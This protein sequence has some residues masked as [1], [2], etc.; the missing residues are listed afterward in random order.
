MTGLEVFMGRSA[1]DTLYSLSLLLC[2][3][4]RNRCSSSQLVTLL[5]A[6]VIV[7]EHYIKIGPD[8]KQINNQLKLSGNVLDIVPN[9]ILKVPKNPPGA[10]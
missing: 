2:L 6:A 10:F 9:N 3:L 8:L 1:R 5:P 7:Q 4:S